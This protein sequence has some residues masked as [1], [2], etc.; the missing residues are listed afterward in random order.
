MSP[1]AALTEDQKRGMERTESRE[2]LVLQ[3]QRIASDANDLSFGSKKE[4]NYPQVH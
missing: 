3:D 2:Q 4:W 1:S